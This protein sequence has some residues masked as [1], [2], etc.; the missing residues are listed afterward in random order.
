MKVYCF[1]RW[2]NIWCKQNCAIKK[3]CVGG[4][5]KKLS[6]A[7]NGKER[8]DVTWRLSFFPCKQCHSSHSRED[9]HNSKVCIVSIHSCLCYSG[10]DRVC[11]HFNPG[12]PIS[13]SSDYLHPFLLLSVFPSRCCSFSTFICSLHRLASVLSEPP[14]FPS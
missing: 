12:A 8:V 11:P 3:K 9:F 14:L 5:G 4:D 1:V 7:L 10:N 13:L 6:V 2:Y